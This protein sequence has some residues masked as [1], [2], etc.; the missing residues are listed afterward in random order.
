MANQY[1]NKAVAQRKYAPSLEENGIPDE[2]VMALNKAKS[3]SSR[4]GVAWLLFED[5]QMV[6][7]YCGLAGDPMF[8]SLKYPP[9]SNRQRRLYLS[10][11][12]HRYSFLSDEL[13]DIAEKWSLNTIC[14][15][16]LSD[17]MS[18]ALAVEILNTDNL[19]TEGL[20]LHT[21]NI[22]ESNES[23]FFGPATLKKHQRPWT[24]CFISMNSQGQAVTYDHF[25]SGFGAE[26]TFHHSLTKHTI[27]A[28][29][30]GLSQSDPQLMAIKE[31][32]CAIEIE[33]AEALAQLQAKLAQGGQNTLV[34]LC[35]NGF[36]YELANANKVDECRTYVAL[37][38]LPHF[39]PLSASNNQKTQA[40]PNL[41]G[42]KVT[43]T[44]SFE[45]G[46][47]IQIRRENQTF[48]H[49]I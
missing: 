30:K 34:T 46:V 47:L 13:I 6:A 26:S 36:F 40:V 20:T 7:S 49:E 17:D 15:P 23:L 12:P 24:I 44:H 2:L 5:N 32:C 45:S 43:S 8:T 14:Y 16:T 4:N 41:F 39:K 25:F 9:P 19:C 27:V 37:T 21:P 38:D 11:P 3:L 35:G 42:W 33:N 28:V 10:T 18:N 1:K 31:K 48:D 22:G 29:E